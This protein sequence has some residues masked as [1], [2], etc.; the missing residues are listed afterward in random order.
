VAE[1]A[2]KLWGLDAPAKVAMTDD[3]PQGIPLA[4]MRKWM[5]R[6]DAIDAEA[7]EIEPAASGQALAANEGAVVSGSPER[8]GAAGSHDTLSSSKGGTLLRAKRAAP[9]VVRRRKVRSLA[10]TMHA[11]VGRPRSNAG[12]WRGA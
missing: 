10:F 3:E 1:R 5:N 7:V 4:V 8:A 6:T 12:Y 11:G 2:A 9:A